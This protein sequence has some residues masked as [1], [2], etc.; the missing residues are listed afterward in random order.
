MGKQ[1]AVIDQRATPADPLPGVSVDRSIPGPKRTMPPELGPDAIAVLEG[2]TFM[3]SDSRRRRPQGLDRRPRPRR[4]PL[5]EPLGADDQRRTVP[6]PPRRHGRLLLGRVLPDQPAPRGPRG[7]QRRAAPAA[8]C[9]RRPARAARARELPP[10]A[11]QDRAP[12]RGRQR[13]RRPV[14]DQGP[15][16]R[17]IEAD[18]PDAGRRPVRPDLPLHEPD[19]LRGDDP[20][21]LGRGDEDRRRR[22]ALGDRP[23]AARDLGLRAARAAQARP[24]RAPADALGLR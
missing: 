21:G 17:P 22:P 4:H 7:E 1:S 3:Y 10:R 19:L 14:R 6:R 5:P 9:R 11:A 12:P 18:R 2:R 15:G 16:P 20:R 13:L 24:A 8:L 23:A